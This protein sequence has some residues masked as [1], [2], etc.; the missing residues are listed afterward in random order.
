MICKT[1]ELLKSKKGNRI[2]VRSTY[3]VF[4]I[5]ILKSDNISY[6]DQNDPCASLDFNSLD[7]A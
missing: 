5:T 4:G 3:K 7:E 6:P 1:Q 2:I